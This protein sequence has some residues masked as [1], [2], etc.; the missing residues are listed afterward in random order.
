MATSFVDERYAPVRAEVTEFDLPVR[1]TIPD[2]LDGRYLR[3][4]PNPIADMAPDEYN[5]FTGDGMVHGVRLSG[6]H[7]LWY[8]NRWVDSEVTSAAL[9]RPAPPER[10]RSPLHGPSANTNVIGFA[11]KTLALVEAGV[12]CAELSYDLDTVDVC[13]FDGTVR[14][15]YTAHPLVDPETGELH[16]VSYHFGRGDAVLH[17]VIG[18]DGRLRRRVPIR[19]G[20]S[21]MM[22]AFSLTRDYVVVYDLPVTFDVRSVVTAHVARPLRPLAALALGAAIGRVRVPGPVM[23]RLPSAR[24]G[25][26]PYRWNERYPA[27]VGLI[28]RHGDPTPHWLEVEP[29]YVFHPVNAASADGRV[30]V[31]LVVH[32]RVF[33]ADRTGPSEGRPRLERWELNPRVSCR[34]RRT[35]L[36]DEHVE[37]P[38]FDERFTASRHHDCWLVVGSDDLS[39]E[40]R[41]IRTDSTHGVAAMRDFGP[42]SS[43]GEFVFHPESPDSP[44]GH[45]VVMGLVTDLATSSTELRILDART[46]ED[47]AAVALPQRVPAGFHGNWIPDPDSAH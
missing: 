12:A 4:G 7:A 43:V 8:R 25:S 5:W 11:G 10:G 32:E 31:D 22:H 26:F 9:H 24:A 17:T 27:R 40:H 23:D 15:G 2:W 20:G 41:L 18:P 29:C 1:G 14:G 38:R 36:A 28:P 33:D 45:G 19:V 3:N 46:L 44:E 39:G 6:G 13:D 34:V 16:A 42:H 30:V 21:P 47:R 35:R 37:F